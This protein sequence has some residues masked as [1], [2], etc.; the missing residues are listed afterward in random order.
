MTH[1]DRLK[2]F[3]WLLLFIIP[4]LLGIMVNYPVQAG[5]EPP[6]LKM[7]IQPTK[8]IYSIR[9]GLVMKFIFTARSKAK[10]CLDKDIFS[11][12]QV[13]IAKPGTGK[14]PLKPLVLKDNSQLFQESMKVQW[15][16]AGES[17]TLRASLENIVL[18]RYLIC[19]SKHL[20]RK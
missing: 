17:L 14:I 13:T 3:Y 12:M 6:V 16:E 19:V 4:I 20:R 15:L 18:V 7:E 9:E 10:L 1:V 8:Q 5:E 2:Q 11:Q